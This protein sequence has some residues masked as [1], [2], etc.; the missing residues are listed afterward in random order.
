MIGV[1]EWRPLELPGTNIP[2]LTRTSKSV[3]GPDLHTSMALYSV[4]MKTTASMTNTASQ[5]VA[6]T[7]TWSRPQ[8]FYS[9]KY[10][11]HGFLW[12]TGTTIRHHRMLTGRKKKT[13]AFWVKGVWQLPAG[14][15]S[16]GIPGADDGPVKDHCLSV[17]VFYLGPPA[18]ERSRTAATAA[19]AN[20]MKRRRD[21]ILR[22]RPYSAYVRMIKIA[23]SWIYMSANLSVQP[24]QP[25]LTPDDGLSG[26]EI[27]LMVELDGPATTVSWI[28]QSGYCAREAMSCPYPFV[29]ISVRV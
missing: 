22:L 20:K 17:W 1:N 16:A 27:Y 12:I 6:I 4:R 11:T 25:V 8:R 14:S 29:V 5:G 19:P 24:E 10:C 7:I 18:Q 15:S 23:G 28:G 26:H 3:L 21:S 13:Y 9:T 2:S